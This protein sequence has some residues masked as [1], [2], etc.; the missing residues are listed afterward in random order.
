MSDFPLFYAPDVASTASLP[1]TEVAH[2]CRVLRLSAGEEIEVT[3]GQGHF[4]H[5]R[6]TQ[7][8]KR[9]CSLELLQKNHW[10]PYWGGRITIAIAPT[11]NMDRMEWMTEK[12]VEMGVD[13]IVFMQT[14]QCERK[15]IRADRIERIAVSAMKQSLKA[16]LPRIEVGRPFSDFV[17]SQSSSDSCRLIAHCSSQKDLPQRLPFHKLY[18]GQEDVVVMIG[19]EGDFS[20][21]E[22]Q[23]AI[24]FGFAPLSLG[25]ARLRTETAALSALSWIHAIQQMRQ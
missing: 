14:S 18:K 7:V 19:P 25:E 13:T 5:A 10:Q 24:S 9:G 3:D 4:Y 1:E 23:E 20:L 11:K 17:R 22:V 2:C 21:Q 15:Q 12:L 6:L 8:D 16:Y